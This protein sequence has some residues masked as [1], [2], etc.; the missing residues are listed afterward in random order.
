MNNLIKIVLA[1][2]MI[3][4]VIYLW[5][6]ALGGDAE[7]LIVQGPSM[8]PTIKDGSLV[9]TKTQPNYQIDDIVSFDLKESGIH[10]IVVHRIIEEREDGFVIKG[11][12]N[13]RKDPGF[14]TKEQIRGK[15]I[16]ATP[17]VG[18]ALEYLRNPVVFVLFTVVTLAYQVIQ[19]RKKQSKEKLRRISLG[20]PP[21]S[22]EQT[23]KKQNKKPKKPDYTLFFG[24]LGFN[25]AI[26][27][28]TQISIY[29]HYVPIRKLGDDITGFLYKIFN[30]DFA[31]TLI[32]AFYTIVILGIYF[33]TKY[34][35][36]RIS[37]Q[38]NKIL[39]SKNTHKKSSRALQQILGNQTNPVHV[40][41]QFVW[42]LFIIFFLFQFL[43]VAGGMIESITNP[44]DPT[45]ALC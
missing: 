45:K 9:I 27:I 43:T 11:D 33:I 20:L 6:V 16:F 19:K 32:F 41:A 29:E 17:Y 28:I 40:A 25:I 10:R 7:I 38:K 3:P 2:M 26:Y 22:K 12:N 34:Y 35:Q 14:P 21:Q 18:D 24:A 13:P 42:F 44:C 39:N 23:A 15:V 4:L 36:R 5:P 31:N 37:K 8:L 1:A 30:P